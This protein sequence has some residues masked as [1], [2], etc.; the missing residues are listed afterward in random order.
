MLEPD[1]EYKFLWDK[2]AS[3]PACVILQALYDCDKMP[4]YLFN[5]WTTFPSPDFVLIRATGSK[6]M[7]F[8]KKLHQETT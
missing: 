3:R 6:I 8:A 4:C 1:K 5:D 7:E 2:A